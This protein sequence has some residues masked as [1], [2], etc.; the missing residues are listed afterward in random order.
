MLNQTSMDFR[1]YF[2]LQFTKQMIIHSSKKNFYEKKEVL[3]TD[4]PKIPQENPAPQKSDS[5]K[6]LKR[7]FAETPTRKRLE[8][9]DVQK[10][11]SAVREIKY[12]QMPMIRP[13]MNVSTGRTIMHKIPSIQEPN[14]PPNLQYIQPFPTD[15]EIDI[16]KLNP[17]VRDPAVKIIECNGPDENIIVRG[18]MGVKPTDIV[19]TNSEVNDIIEKFSSASKIPV[20][21]GVFNVAVGKLVL[22]AIVSEIINSRFVI[23]KILFSTGRINQDFSVR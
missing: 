1:K 3:T 18:T 22:T 4:T 15:T 9:R 19:L 16:G 11:K 8:P 21:E 23:K 10:I 7:D 12:P 14:L 17:L 2:L 5:Q 13:R 20:H 6:I